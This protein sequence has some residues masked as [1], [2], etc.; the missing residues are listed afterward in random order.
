MREP[1]LPAE[2]EDDD[3][4]PPEEWTVKALLELAR[5][6]E[7]VRYNPDRDIK[8]TSNKYQ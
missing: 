4:M 6:G 1:M 2:L 5:Q 7:V 8:Q 3:T